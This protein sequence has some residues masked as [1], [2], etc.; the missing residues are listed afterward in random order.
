MTSARPGSV[1]PR[2]ASRREPLPPVR[3]EHT[4]AIIQDFVSKVFACLPAPGS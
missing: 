1:T 3:A 4:T 2:N